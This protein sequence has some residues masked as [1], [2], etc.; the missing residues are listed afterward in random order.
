MLF[1]KAFKESV[2][3]RPY[4][5]WNIPRDDPTRLIYTH[6]PIH[7]LLYC[8]ELF[9]V[10]FVLPT[11]VILVHYNYLLNVRTPNCQRGR[12]SLYCYTLAHLIDHPLLQQETSRSIDTNCRLSSRLNLSLI[13]P[14]TRSGDSP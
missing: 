14:S 3:T 2:S 7:P 12:T 10:V 5:E 8:F 9:Y 1:Y 11:L 6:P 4:I 13:S